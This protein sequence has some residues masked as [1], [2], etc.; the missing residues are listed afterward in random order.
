MRKIWWLAGLF[1]SLLVLAGCHT[2]HKETP[3]IPEKQNYTFITVNADGV[4]S[5]N[6]EKN[7]LDDYYNRDEQ[8]FQEKKKELEQWADYYDNTSS[9]YDNDT[10]SQYD[11]QDGFHIHCNDVRSYYKLIQSGACSKYRNEQYGMQFALPSNF[12]TCKILQT[13]QF[14]VPRWEMNVGF[15]LWYP[16]SWNIEEIKDTEWY[17]I[18]KT[19]NMAEVFDERP[20]GTWRIPATAIHICNKN[21]F[22][23]ELI[24]VNSGDQEYWVDG[25]GNR[26]FIFG[27]N[28]KYYFLGWGCGN[29]TGLP[30]DEIQHLFSEKDIENI[31]PKWCVKTNPHYVWTNKNYHINC[32]ISY[33]LFTDKDR[34]STFEI[35]K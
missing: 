27:K 35:E 16:Y 4:A 14:V 28:S 17:K 6:E 15:E 34:F 33:D 11:N 24:L 13:I 5:V 2:L 31:T 22:L 12:D 3:S 21:K 9:Y 8:I 18:S 7:G 32:V 29:L 26:S 30:E 25:L 23:E 19:F 20:F 1:I 10:S